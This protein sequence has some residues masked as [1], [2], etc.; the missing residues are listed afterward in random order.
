MP[1]N[2]LKLKWLIFQFHFFFVFVLLK[3]LFVPCVQTHIWSWIQFVSCNL[4]IYSWMLF[5]NNIVG[6]RGTRACFSF[7]I[8]KHCGYLYFYH[9]SQIATYNADRSCW[10]HQ[11]GKSSLHWMSAYLSCPWKFQRIYSILWNCL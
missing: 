3:Q 9:T 11:R 4:F 8:G 5:N 6:L 10:C 7:Y 2:S 1:G